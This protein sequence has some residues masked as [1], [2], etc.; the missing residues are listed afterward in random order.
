LHYDY[1]AILSHALSRA[2]ILALAATCV[3]LLVFPR[4]LFVSGCGSTIYV[5]TGERAVAGSWTADVLDII[6]PADPEGSRNFVYSV[7]A[8]DT[9]NV[10]GVGSS[11]ASTCCVG[12]G[13]AYCQIP[14]VC[15]CV[16]VC[17]RR[18]CDCVCVV[19]ACVP[20]C[21]CMCVHVSACVW[22][23]GGGAFFLPL[24]MLAHVA[25]P[26]GEGHLPCPLLLSALAA[27]L[28]WLSTP[29]GFLA[30]F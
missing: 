28:L 1:D 12:V 17:V 10:F 11:F 3:P 7:V 18:V 30:E 26:S 29:S 19:C 21:A 6:P 23:G 20:V 14:C 9:N 2:P 27:V 4:S 25:R 5:E 8:G 24:R 15:D 16:C 13:V 22:E